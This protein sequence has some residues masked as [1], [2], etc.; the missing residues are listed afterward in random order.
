MRLLAVLIC[1]LGLAAGSPQARAQAQPAPVS[2]PSTIA[3]VGDSLADGLWGGLYRLLQKD[4]RYALFR[5][6]KHS[7]GFTGMDLL[8]LI[9][10]AFSAGEVHALVM[11]IGANDRRSYFL[12]GKPKAL[13]GTPEWIELYAGRI[14]R[15][16]DHAGKRNVPLVW[17]LL[18]VMRDATGTR[19]ARLVNG[20]IERE[21]KR[22]PFV[23]LIETERLTSDDKGQYVAHFA[24]LKGQKRQMRAGDGVH[25][26]Q[27]G[28]EVIGDL[29]LKRLAEVSPRFKPLAGE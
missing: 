17:V 24:D 11:M 10:K 16:M 2:S 5:G 28:Y 7:L 19:D 12:D 6:A 4:K 8:D 18:P 13:L 23:A 3:I 27:A 14:G 1:V 25:F 26:E 20:I 22:R 21:A 29:I 15:F 9:D